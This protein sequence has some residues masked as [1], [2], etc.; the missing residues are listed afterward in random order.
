MAEQAVTKAWGSAEQENLACEA[1]AEDV[2]AS[3]TVRPGQVASE[4]EKGVIYA[5]V[6]IAARIR[7]RRQERDEPPTGPSPF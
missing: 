6:A 4:Y 2:A 7:A 3:H 5:A 1:V